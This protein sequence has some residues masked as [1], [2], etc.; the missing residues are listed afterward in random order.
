MSAIGWMRYLRICY[1]AHNKR[2][3]DT[4][5]EGDETK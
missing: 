2:H 5:N 4:L 1:N 3:A